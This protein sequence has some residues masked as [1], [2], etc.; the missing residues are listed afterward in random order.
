MKRIQIITGASSGIGREFALQI[1]RERN[2]DE[3][4]L[5]AR[6]R[7]RL[8]SLAAEIAAFGAEA[9]N[10]AATG[11]ATRAFGPNAGA[12]PK[13]RVVELDIGGRKGVDALAS[14]L[15]SEADGA[16]DGGLVVDAL[17]NNAGFGTY[18]TFA[19]TAIDRQLDMIELN[20]V[21]LTALCHAALPYLAR[22]SLVVNVASLAA[23]APLGNFA[24]YG[25]TKAYSLSFT[26]ALAAEV[27]DSG[28]RVIA[29]C[30]GPVDTEFANVA[31]NGARTAVVDGKSPAAVVAHCLR[32]ARKG[33]RVAVM[34]PKWKVKAFISRI[35]GRYFV[36]R[37]TYVHDK[38]PSR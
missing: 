1:A 22:G 30:P 28:V 37:Y 26:L 19:D 8:E 13:A 20:C 4:W 31:S 29:L 5:I 36:A 24:V 16:G 15:K 9:N 32:A 7:D 10:G 34:A 2:A 11:T 6:R 18:G 27:A 35:V 23:F 3:M 17:V 33:K 12:A 21:A 25:A 14:M 38:R